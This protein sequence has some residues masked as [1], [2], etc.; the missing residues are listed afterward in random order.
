M[1]I[2]CGV[3]IP[4]RVFINDDVVVIRTGAYIH[5]IYSIQDR[6]ASCDLDP[7]IYLA[8]TDASSNEKHSLY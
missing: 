2:L 7:P 8:R 3:S 6:V 1:P 4:I 5:S